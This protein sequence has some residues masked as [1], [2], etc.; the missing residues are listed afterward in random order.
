VLRIGL[1]GGIACGKSVVGGF[2]AG[3]GVPVIDDDVAARDAVAPGSPGL[4]AVVR[5]FGDEVLGPDGALDRPRLGRIVFADEARRRRL[6]AITFPFIGY[7]LRERF[8]AA[9]QSG[10]RMLVYESALLIENGGADAWRPLVV[11]RATLTQQL[12]RL[13]SR[14]G[15]DAGEARRR[16]AA[17]MPVDEKAAFA[18]HVIDNSGTVAEARRQFDRI[19][20]ALER[21]AR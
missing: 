11:V 4:A 6:M 13:G 7:L 2:F 21:L 18:D 19:F 1:T 5:E 16:I 14:S 9:E 20:A 15:L 12:E 8:R 3:C 10:T 17:Q